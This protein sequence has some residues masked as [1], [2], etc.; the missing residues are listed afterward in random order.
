MAKIKTDKFTEKIREKLE[1]K[2]DKDNRE[3]CKF[4]EKS[5]GKPV[6]EIDQEKIKETYLYLHPKIKTD[7]DELTDW[8]AIKTYLKG[9]PRGTRCSYNDENV[10]AHVDYLPV[11]NPG[12]IAEDDFDLEAHVKTTFIF[13]PP[14]KSA[15]IDPDGEGD[16][17]H[18][19]TCEWEPAGR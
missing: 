19:R 3:I 11:E 18:R 9:I 14:E 8:E 16:L 5:F 7:N 10:D 2:I 1:R 17:R 13:E 6:D 4:F 15:G 12:G